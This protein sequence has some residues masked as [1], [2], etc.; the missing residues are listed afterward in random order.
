[1]SRGTQNIFGKEV[2]NTIEGIFTCMAIYTRRG[3][4][5]VLAIVSPYIIKSVLL[6]INMTC[7]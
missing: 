5:E 7:Y 6:Y 3:A 1:M 4:I 2:R